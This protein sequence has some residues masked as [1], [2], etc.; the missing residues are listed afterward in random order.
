MLWNISPTVTSRV[1]ANNQQVILF[2]CYSG[3]WIK[4][5]AENVVDIPKTKV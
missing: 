1:T 2:K 4:F 5:N 3:F